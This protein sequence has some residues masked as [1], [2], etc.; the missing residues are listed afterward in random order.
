MGASLDDVNRLL[1]QRYS[2]ALT[3]QLNGMSILQYTERWARKSHT[4]VEALDPEYLAARTAWQERW[5]AVYEEG[6]E[7]GWLY[8]D[9]YDGV[10]LTSEGASDANSVLKVVYDETVEEWRA[11][12]RELNGGK[13]T[14][15]FPV[16]K[17]DDT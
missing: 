10:D 16:V 3:R 15:T 1:S 6:V 9:S 5:K 14:V 13:D 8:D 12:Q 2:E 7:K 11:R 4:E 17:R